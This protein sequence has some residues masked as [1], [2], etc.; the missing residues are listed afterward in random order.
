MSIWRNNTEFGP[1]DPRRYVDVGFS[2][3]LQRTLY[4]NTAMSDDSGSNLRG[5]GARTP[6]APNDV[7]NISGVEREWAAAL[8][9][10]TVPYNTGYGDEG[11]Q[12]AYNITSNYQSDP[13]YDELKAIADKGDLNPAQ[14][15]EWEALNPGGDSGPSM[16]EIIA[17]QRAQAKLAYE[18]GLRNAR[19]AYNRAQAMH[20]EAMGTLGTRR[21]EFENA[22]NQGNQDITQEYQKR[23]GE[24]GTSAQNRKM[25]DLAVLQVMGLNGSALERAQGMRMRDQV[26]AQS[27]L[28][29]NRN[30]NQVTNKN[31]W[32]TNKQWALGQEGAINRALEQ[33]ESDRRNAEGFAYENYLG[34]TSDI[35][36]GM[37][38]YMDSIQQHQNAM[39]AAGLANQNYQANSFTPSLGDFSSYLQPAQAKAPQAVAATG[40]QASDV[41]LSP[42]A[43]SELD[44][45][46]KAGVYGSGLYNA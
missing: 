20:A 40:D 7:R 2:E 4:P 35:D 33:A 16:E 46:K 3:W 43:L 32:D 15:T 27:E 11:L 19:D 45:L 17:K 30:K 13:R 10:E 39:Q 5:D 9:G 28:M 25:K 12:D 29:D 41:S 36:K 6:V 37:R 1:L 24:L 22:F 31:V 42:Y 14:K 18:R 8:P 26:R 44:R 21:E 34:N 23:G 38:S